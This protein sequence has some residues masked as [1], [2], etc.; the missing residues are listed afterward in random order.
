MNMIIANSGDLAADQARYESY[1]K[2][3]F[4][5]FGVDV[6]SL[7]GGA[8]SQRQ[9]FEILSEVTDLNERTVLD[10]GCG[11]GDFYGFLTR[12]KGLRLK[13]YVGLDLTQDFIGEAVHRYATAP[14]ASFA[15]VDFLSWSG[16]EEFDVAVA[17]GIF[18]LPSEKWEDY[19]LVVCQKMF[20]HA[21]RGIAVN[22]L[23]TC[24]PQPDPH[25]KYSRPGV[26]LELLMRHISP[27]AVLR[28]DYR[29]NDFTIY[30]YPHPTA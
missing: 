1:F 16:D 24:S 29:L 28:H 3:R 14:Q 26:T 8:A 25:S 11:F 5:Q 10:V 20:R 15:K 19:V 18:F 2:G 9:R 22:F 17:S 21:R 4:A 6:R 13:K 7:W 12:D 23:S 30:L 27:A